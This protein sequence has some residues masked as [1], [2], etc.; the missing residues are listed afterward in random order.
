MTATSKLL[1]NP[2][3]RWLLTL[4]WTALIAILLVQPENQPLI[5][6]GIPPGPN[7]PARELVF[8]LLHLLAFGITCAL[9]FHALSAHCPAATSLLLAGGIAIVIGGSTEYL[10]TFAPD[11]YPSWGDFIAN[12]AGTLIAARLIW[13]RRVRPAP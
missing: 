12:C 11:R 9:W 13:K 6:T 5:P 3:L 4:G 7:T 10:Q 2:A 8:G 1:Q